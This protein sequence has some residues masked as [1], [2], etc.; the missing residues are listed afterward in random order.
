MDIKTYTRRA[1]M[2]VDLVPCEYIENTSLAYIDT[3]IEN[4]A[5]SWSIDA[6]IS[7]NEAKTGYIIGSRGAS[8][9]YQTIYVNSAMNF[10]T[11]I[12]NTT[13]TYSD[14]TAEIEKKYHL[15]GTPK[16]LT[17]TD[18][19]GQSFTITNSGGFVSNGHSLT[20]FNLKSYIIEANAFLGRVYSLK[21]Y[22]NNVLVRDYMPMFKKSTGEY[23]LNDNLNGVF[24]GSANNNKFTGK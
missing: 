11:R 23:G 15:V 20:L 14:Y 6:V 8:R 19:D 3:N 12:N 10:V 24:Y 21:L 4:G 9:Y 2:M 18:E 17:V 13:E 1:A 5:V 16:R 22:R 7:I